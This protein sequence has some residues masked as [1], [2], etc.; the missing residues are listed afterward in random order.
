MHDRVIDLESNIKIYF[1]IVSFNKYKEI[2]NDEDK[3]FTHADMSRT[4]FFLCINNR[5]EHTNNL[6]NLPQIFFAKRQCM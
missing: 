1:H 5:L 4:M 3:D 2:F 6:A